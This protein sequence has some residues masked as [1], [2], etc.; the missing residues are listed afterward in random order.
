MVSILVPV[1]DGPQYNQ[2]CP[3]FLLSSPSKTKHFRSISGC[4]GV[5]KGSTDRF[6]F[7]PIVP[8]LWFP[9]VGLNDSLYVNYLLWWLYTRAYTHAALWSWVN[10]K[11]ST[12]NDQ[13]R[14]RLLLSVKLSEWKMMLV[15]VCCGQLFIEHRTG[16]VDWPSTISHKPA[17][18]RREE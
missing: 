1:R 7:S 5:R 15:Y 16:V 9:V 14:S 11:Y 6:S 13:L 4:L 18:I 2:K 8:F 3:S 10:E 17:K 12:E